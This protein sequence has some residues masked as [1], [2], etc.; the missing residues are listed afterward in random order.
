[1]KFCS[2]LFTIRQSILIPAVY[3]PRKKAP[4]AQKI[5]RA[6]FLYHKLQQ[7]SKQKQL[8]INNNNDEKF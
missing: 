4:S 2:N 3:R 5:D 8:F 1:M 6:A 7:S